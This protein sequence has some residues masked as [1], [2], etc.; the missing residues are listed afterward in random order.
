[1]TSPFFGG[2]HR[3]TSTKNDDEQTGLAELID[4]PL[5]Q[6]I[7]LLLPAIRLGDIWRF[8]TSHGTPNGLVLTG[9][10]IYKWMI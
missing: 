3:R 5:V 7:N 2:E 9:K 8:P 1:M 6:L 4:I 10:S